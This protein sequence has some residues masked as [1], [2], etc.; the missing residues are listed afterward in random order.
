[1]NLFKKSL[2]LKLG[3]KLVQKNRN[4]FN[5]P[6]YLRIPLESSY[7]PCFRFNNSF[8][9]HPVTLIYFHS[10]EENLP[11]TIKWLEELSMTLKLDVL[12]FEYPSYFDEHDSY[13]ENK[14]ND[15][16][17]ATYNYV[18]KQIGRKPSE[19]VLYGKGSGCGPTLYLAYTHR[20]DEIGGIVLVNPTIHLSNLS[21]S[22]FDKPARMK[23]IKCPVQIVCGE[24][25]P[26]K[27]QAKKLY[28]LFVNRYDFIK[29]STAT[30]NL[31]QSHT[32]Q[33][34]EALIP[35]LC[36]VHPALESIFSGDALTHKKP[37]VYENPFDV[38]KNYLSLGGF[39]DM[40]E[41]LI[42]YG[43]NTIEDIKKMTN[44]DIGIFEL[45]TERLSCFK[46][47]IQVA[48]LPQSVSQ[49]PIRKVKNNK[50]N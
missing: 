39:E 27:N 7:V 18:N 13:N 41:L 30:M 11:Q 17:E 8:K 1:M 43:F 24:L 23:K 33:L 14:L 6:H 9:K 44:E 46:S 40:T 2:S 35:F 15:F 47:F 32:D 20:E 48:N 36:W 38:V 3:S 28:S 4:L 22:L 50:L 45:N 16:S 37:E 19:I 5:G 29:I 10:A 42:S 21:K 12:S 26:E 25:L 34:T 31:E 49:H